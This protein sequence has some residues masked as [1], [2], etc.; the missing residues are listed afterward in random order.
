MFEQ[1]LFYLVA[2]KAGTHGVLGR[3]GPL[4]GRLCEHLWVSGGPAQAAAARLLADLA[5]LGPPVPLSGLPGSARADWVASGAAELTGYA[6][7]EPQGSPGAPASAVRA[8]L[9]V[10]AACTGVADLPG[11]D[12]LADRAR[13]AGLTRAAPRSVGGAFRALAARDGWVGLS[14]SRPSDVELLPALVGAEPGAHE[15]PFDRVAGWAR[16]RTAA[17]VDAR[18][19]L[20]GLPGGRI[21]DAPESG[22][23]GVIVTPGPPRATVERPLVVDLTS[24]WAGPLCAHLL[25]RAGARVVKVESSTRPD[26]ARRGTP[27]FFDRLHDGHEFRTVDFASTAGRRELAEL[28]A[29]ADVV[30]EASR[31]RALLHLGIDA[32]A[33]VAR[34]AVWASITAYGRTRPDRVGFGDDVAAAAGLVNIGPDG[35]YP[36]G[37][38]IADPLAGVYA[39]AAVAFALFHRRAALLDVSMYDVAR[40]AAW[41]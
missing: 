26:A 35:P 4:A 20:L 5:V 10:F 32:E 37:D 14:L 12:L 13:S 34:S 3:L 16:Q 8:A 2:A 17:E 25:G 15:E 31:P 1:M 22:R 23:P 7:G 41:A 38:A 19:A 33:C 36:V 24:L 9:A 11:V 6:D 27:E 30:L 28:I 40:Q 21:V 29:S 39:A 18:F